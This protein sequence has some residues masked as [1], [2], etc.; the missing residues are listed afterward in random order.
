MRIIQVNFELSDHVH[1]QAPGYYQLP[2]LGTL[3]TYFVIH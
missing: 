1:V 3:R 2:E